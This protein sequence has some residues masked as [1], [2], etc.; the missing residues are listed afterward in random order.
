LARPYL[1]KTPTL[2][3]ADG[4]AQSEGPEFKPQYCE[5]KKIKINVLIFPRFY[6][7]LHPPPPPPP[8]TSKSPT[9]CI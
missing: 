3:R 1:E 7:K 9:F 4:V 6:F 2:K 8:V 5:V